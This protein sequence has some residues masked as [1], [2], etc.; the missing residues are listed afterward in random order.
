QRDERLVRVL[1]WT[2]GGLG[3]YCFLWFLLLQLRGSAALGPWF[4]VF[5][6]TPRAAAVEGNLAHMTLGSLLGTLWCGLAVL[7]FWLWRRGAVG[8]RGLLG[9]LL[10]VTVADLA[11]VDSPFVEVVR[12][13]QFFPDDPGITALRQSLGPGERALAFPGIFPTEGHLATYDIPQVFGYHG[14]QLRWYDELTRRSV[15]EGASG[16]QAAQ[17][18]WM[19]FLASPV[20][21]ILA[22]RVVIVPF[23]VDLPGYQ[24]MGG[25]N[26]LAIYRNTRA[27]AA[28]TVVP[29]VRVEPDSAR[30]LTEL[31]DPAF[32]PTSAVLA[33]DSVTAL[34][35]GGGHGQASIESAGADTVAVRAN[36]DGPAMLLLSRNWHPSWRATVNGAPAPVVRVDY[37]LLGVPLSGPGTF[38]VEF[39]YQPAIVFLARHISMAAWI[40]VLVMTAMT[41]VGLWRKRSLR[42]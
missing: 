42:A 37:S 3:L 4:A 28:A 35:Q 6:E 2:F 40:L 27:L 19:E 15:R 39:R 22:A 32:D 23:R 30:Q 41:G 5:G 34:G 14:N 12:Y 8:A 24:S 31:W 29:N 11:R 7:G 38:Q 20:L 9:I 17:Q 21:R 25:N 33:F 1:M 10:A 16:Q 13:D 36:T 18:Y 26:Q